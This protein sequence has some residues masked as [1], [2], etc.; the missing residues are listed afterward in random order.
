MLSMPETRSLAARLIFDT[1]VL[2]NFA[3][4]SQVALLEN[5]YA[6]RA[7]TALAVADEIRR[8]LDAGYTYLRAAEA[9]FAGLSPS[10]WLPVLALTSPREHALYIELGISLASGE[11]SCLS[12]AIVQGFI[13]ASDDL[14]ARREAAER[15]VLLTGTVGI[16]VRAVRQQHMALAEANQI[17]AQMITLR[18]RAPVQR[19]DDLI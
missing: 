11:A 12:L 1:T 9:T 19:L 13:L 16:L 4:V 17:L 3:V 18:Y 8:G 6:G 5:L 15:G 14:A 7:C 10:G 2:S